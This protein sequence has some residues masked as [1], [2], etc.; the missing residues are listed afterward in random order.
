MNLRM[1]CEM[2]LTTRFGYG[3]V[4]DV[5]SWLESVPLPHVVRVGQAFPSGPDIDVDAA[6]KQGLEDVPDWDTLP[7]NASLAIG[8]GSRGIGRLAEIVA[9]VVRDVQARGYRPFIFP[10]MGSHGGATPE[11]QAC[12]LA[13]YGVTGEAMG[14]PLDAGMEAVVVGKALD[15]TEVY[16]SAAARRADAIILIN[17]IKPHTDFGGALGSGLLKMSVVGLGKHQGALAFH[18]AAHRMGHEKAL[19]AMARVALSANRVFLGIAVIEDQRHRLARV[20]VVPGNALEE[21]ELRLA[22]EAARLM[23]RLPLNEIDVLIVDRIGKNI[24]G[25]G[26]DPNVIGRMIHGYSLL[27]PELPRC[28]R[29][30][31]I[32]VR[33]L[34]PESHGNATGIGMADFTTERFVQAMDRHSSYTNALTALSLQGCK[35]PIHFATDREAI[36]AALASLGLE[37]SREARVIRIRDTLSLDQLEVS[38]ACINELRTRPGISV[39]G[40]PEPM[41]FDAG[42]NLR[43]L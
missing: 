23:P 33:E 30:R 21:A 13:D 35:V 34:T 1:G 37:D 7:N 8:V 31:R 18:R 27:E 5:I 17:R 3:A 9:S 11:G 10:A 25:T 38:V 14:C 32:L 41:V 12:L 6:L 42:G 22:A 24:S 28:P 40:E 36:L 16:S 2:P 15:G 26:M 43:P 20:E 19:R 39:G 4:S 29:I